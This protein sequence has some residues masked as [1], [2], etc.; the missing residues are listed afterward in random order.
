MAGNASGTTGPGPS[1]PRHTV[2]GLFEDTIDAEQA[3][4]ALRKARHNADRVSLVVRDKAAEEGGPDRATAVARAVVATALDAVG[5]WLQGLASLIVPEHGTYLV[6]GP[7]GAA[8]A[9]IGAADARTRAQVEGPSYVAATGL[10]ADSLL[11]T[12]TEF[13]FNPDEATYLDH[14]LAAGA[15]L[16]AVT[17][18][19]ES[20]LQ[21]TRRLFADH[22][23][24]HIGMAQTDA[25][26]F[27]E[28]EA[29]LAARP[30]VSSGGDVVVADAVA[31]LRRMSQERG[32]P[33]HEALCNRDVVD[34]RGH[35]VGIV[36]EVLVEVVDP[37][38][39][40]G[41]EPARL[42]ERYIVVGFGG[43]LGLGRRHVAVP[44]PLADLTADPISLQI[45]KEVLQRAPTYDEDAPF[46]RREEQAI[47]GYFGVEPYWLQA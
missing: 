3:L 28:A 33:E 5:G 4:V 8:L 13:G 23:A 39:P 22:D 37:D 35:E 11:R 6:A 10:S 12:L 25:G 29:L 9:G 19:D 45:D 2:V 46:S 38:G 34:A 42:V 32:A 24:V 36:E 18:N 44:A 30:E 31:P 41:P 17:T 26:F 43:V 16:V 47:S 21:A 20:G 27:E 40:V 14:R 15:T 7:I 1:M